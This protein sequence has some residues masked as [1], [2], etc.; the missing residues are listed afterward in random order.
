MVFSWCIIYEQVAS[1]AAEYQTGGNAFRLSGGNVDL[2]K[3]MDYLETA[4]ILSLAILKEEQRF[5]Y[6]EGGTR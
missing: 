4:V 6:L 1:N 2:P 3:E 5:I